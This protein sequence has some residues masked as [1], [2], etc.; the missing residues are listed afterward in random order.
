MSILSK[1]ILAGEKKYGA[2]TFLKASS[3]PRDFHRIPTGIFS[4]DLCIGGGIPICATSSA[5]GPP[6]SSKTFIAQKLMVQSSMLCYRCYKYE[7]DCK[8]EDGPLKLKSLYIDA[9]GCV[10]EDQEIFDPVSGF[11]G[12]LKEYVTHD[13]Q[14]IVSYRKGGTLSIES[15]TRLI[16]S[17]I[18]DTVLLKTK[19]TELRVTHNH[20]VL[21]YKKGNPEWVSA[22]D[23]E[24]GDYIARPWKCS[25]EG[26][27]SG[28]SMKEAE[29]IGMMLG[30]GTLTST[31]GSIEFT[32]TN[33]EISDRVGELIRDKNYIVNKQ[34]DRHCRLIMDSK[35][36]NWYKKGDLS[37]LKQWLVDIGMIPQIS[38]ERKI[39]SFLLTETKDIICFLLTGLWMTDGHLNT[40]RPSAAYSSSSRTLIVQVRWL[41]SRLGI[42]GRIHKYEYQNPNHNPTYT[43][44]INGLENLRILDSCL[45]LYSNRKDTLNKWLKHIPKTNKMSSEYLLPDYNSNLSCNK[46]C[47]LNHSD[48]WWDQI[49][50]TTEAGKI[51]CYDASVFQ[52]HSW[53]A[54][55]VI[56][57]NSFDWAW[58]EDIGVPE[59]TDVVY[60]L[61]GEEYVDIYHSALKADDV[62]LVIIDSIADLTPNAEL[63]GSAEDNYVM[64][65]ARLVSY[66]I[67]KGKTILMKERKRGH[68]VAVLMLNQVRAKPAIGGRPSEE[69]PGGNASKHD[70]TL[71]ARTGRRAV[72]KKDATG[73]SEYTL[74]SVSLGSAMSK[75]KLLVL[76]G[77]AEF[78]VVTSNEHE[79]KRGT[80]MDWG[81]VLKRAIDYGF[82]TEV[83]SKRCVFNK[84]EMSNDA[85]FD[86]FREHKEVYYSLQN[87]IIDAA[88][89]EVLSRE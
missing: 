83:N 15:P 82:I 1:V 67:R 57:H 23:I 64:T 71:S 9:E 89:A 32:K 14:N 69:A 63:A 81:A 3:A 37:P 19:T 29:F 41:L 62:G 40:A 88:R 31:D 34:D 74:I 27:S 2:G 22:N 33:D 50:S 4:L 75:K 38:S 11:V 24:V 13:T 18:Q 7:W 10:S 16:D 17:G 79:F 28:I 25:F 5:W 76:A 43:V 46:E 87:R 73:L 59:D 21:L 85:L 20:P 61:T 58:A 80:V 47:F 6:G 72:A 70:F 77:A 66:L 42:L 36:G 84:E 60:G 56:I 78:T 52:H 49:V 35:K 65:Q 44:S 12:T 48:V 68:K 45:T 51:Q 54:N 8:C 26:T 55:D 39:P 86:L 53:V 30:D